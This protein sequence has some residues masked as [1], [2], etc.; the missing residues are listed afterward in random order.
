MSDIQRLQQFFRANQGRAIPLPRLGRVMSP[1][2]VT[3]RIS[4]LR[5]IGFVID[6]QKRTVKGKT[7][8]LYICRVVAP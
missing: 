7:H 8:S 5:Q 2:S 4:E 6:N 1:F 3:K